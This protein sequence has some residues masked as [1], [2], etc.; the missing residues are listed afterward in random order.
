MPSI[1]PPAV[2]FAVLLLAGALATARPLAAQET[3]QDVVPGRD[4]RAHKLLTPGLTDT[5]VLDVEVGEVLHGVVES[6]AFDPV[7]ALADETGAVVA[8]VD[9]AGT[10]SEIRVRA[11]T[12][13]KY[14]FRVSPYQGS[15]GG[16]YEYT[17]RRFRTESISTAGEASHELGVEQWWHWRVALRKGDV[18]V[19]TVLGD[20]RL[21]AVLDAA[22]NTL[23][24]QHGGYHAQQDGDLYVRVE[25]LHRHRVHLVTQLARTGERPFGERHAER[26]AP[27]GLDA[28][29]VP[30][31]AG[32]CVVFDLRMP[33]AE[34]AFD[35]RDLVPSDRGPA[36]VATGHFDKG[37]VR[38]QLFF[39]RR[40]TTLGVQLRNRTSA[41]APYELALR[42]WGRD[43]ELGDEVA[44]E[45]PLGDGALFHLPLAAGELVELDVASE[46]FDASL[47]VWD[48]DGNVVANVDDRSPVDRDP[49]HRF[50]VTR[51]GTWHVLVHGC[52]GRASGAFTLRTKSE[53]LPV[54]APGVPASVKWGSHLHLELGAGETVWLSLRSET[55]DGALQVI[56]PAGDGG[57]VAEGGGVG[58]DVLVAYRARHAG[59]HT[60][61]VHARSGGGSGELTVVR[62][63]GSRP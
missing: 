25:G 35:L 44:A 58:G 55:F 17:L 42:A 52:G 10:R 61:L 11:A 21:T 22:G 9:G 49:K 27:Y 45:L 56:D 46:R 30:L 18:L 38:R 62:P 23:G 6:H 47:D 15:G 12:K 20:G 60:L 28:W 19:P 1:A 54:L 13:G 48:P 43:V 16:Q 32:A 36:F 34:L 24:E 14:A 5:W 33:E 53:P 3:R 8:T 26:V 59:R 51:P 41:P 50:L 31:P 63:A 7:L 2:P 29:R 57:F 4:F 40:A 39:V 37:G